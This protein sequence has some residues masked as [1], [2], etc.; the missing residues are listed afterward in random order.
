MKTIYRFTVVVALGAAVVG[1][2]TV[3]LAPGADRVRLTT[4]AADVASCRAVGSV[5]A[6]SDSAFDGEADIR[7]QALGLGANS[8]FV[9]RYV[10]GKEEGVAYACP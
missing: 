5:K 4:R 6:N 8:V 1:C 2:A 7:N 9:T 3:A 10:T